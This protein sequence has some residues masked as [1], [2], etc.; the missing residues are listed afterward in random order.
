MQ[1]NSALECLIKKSEVKPTKLQNLA[2]DIFSWLAENPNLSGTQVRIAP[3]GV[4]N[5]YKL[6]I[7]LVNCI[8]LF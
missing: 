5:S 2:T 4:Y 6:F 7:L 1:I 3:T 8:Y